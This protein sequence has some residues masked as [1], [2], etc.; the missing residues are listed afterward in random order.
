MVETI[1]TTDKT[2]LY[3]CLQSSVYPGTMRS[4]TREDHQPIKNS[5]EERLHFEHRSIRIGQNSLRNDLDYFQPQKKRSSR[6]NVGN[7]IKEFGKQPILE[8]KK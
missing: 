3:L 1:G 5:P 7:A 4:V 6:R 8:H 2:L